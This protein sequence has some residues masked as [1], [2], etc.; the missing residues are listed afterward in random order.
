MYESTVTHMAKQCLTSALNKDVPS[1]TLFNMYIDELEKY[2]DDIDGDSLCSF[3]M[4]VA[5]LLCDDDVVVVF[6]ESVASL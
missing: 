1:P 6:Y 4:M 5:I 2:L 3:D